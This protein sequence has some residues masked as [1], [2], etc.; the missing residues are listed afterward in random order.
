MRTLREA[1]ADAK[2]GGYAIPHFNVTDLAQLHAVARV[3]KELD[4]PILVGTSE[5]ERT[6]IGAERAVALIRSYREEGIQLYLNA[7]HTHSVE[8]IEEAARAGYDEVLFDGGAL[9]WEDN[10]LMTTAAV[11]LARSINPDIIV[12]GELGY[13]GNGSSLL[14]VLPEGAALTAES[15]TSVEQAIAF[16][17]ST[18]IDMLAPA[19]G[20]IHGMLKNSPNPHLDIARIKAI[21]DATSVP[22]VLHGGSGTPTEDLIAA[23]QNGIDVA[24]ISTELRLAWR[25]GVEKGLADHPGEVNPAKVMGEAEDEVYEAALSRAK[26]FL[27]RT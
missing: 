1:L 6:Y 8:K 5:G 7:D 23:V 20:N 11:Q 16:V 18:G 10:V 4:T 25:K 27:R 2:A 3:A 17:Q 22:L 21:A 24:H 13:I 9:S 15:M 26:L 14:D 19:V 12:E